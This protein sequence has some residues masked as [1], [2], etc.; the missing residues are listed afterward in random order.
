MTAQAAA[1]L[2]ELFTFNVPQRWSVAH[3]TQAILN[4]EPH[5]PAVRWLTT[6]AGYVHYRLTGENVMGVGE[7]SG[8][9]P[10]DPATGTYNARMMKAFEAKY[11]P[12]DFT[13]PFSIFCQSIC[14]LVFPLA[15]ADMKQYLPDCSPI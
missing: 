11:G 5:V 14:N 4:K 8:M 2:S 13:A 7:A 1:E 15:I 6:L 3:Y 9:F 10:I 12:L